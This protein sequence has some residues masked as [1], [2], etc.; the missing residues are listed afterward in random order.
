MHI[1]S[2]SEIHVKNNNY[3]VADLLTKKFQELND[4]ICEIDEANNIIRSSLDTWTYI[5]KCNVQSVNTDFSENKKKN[6]KY[7][8][9]ECIENEKLLESLTPQ[10]NNPLLFSGAKGVLINTWIIMIHTFLFFTNSFIVYPTN[11]LFIARLGYS[12]YITGIVLAM[13]PLSSFLILQLFIANISF[14][15]YKITI[16]LAVL[17]LLISNIL[18][19]YSYFFKSLSMMVLSRFLLGLGGIRILSN[20]YITEEIPSSNIL[21]YSKI[22]FLVVWLGYANGKLSY[23]YSYI[24]FNL[25]VLFLLGLLTQLE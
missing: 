24:V 3:N 4:K 25:K 5:V 13:T 16:I 19:V 9:I 21:Y 1:K 14:R 22:D 6:S 12:S 2:L 15:Y 7:N 23:I 17:V 11:Y 20:R 10:I 8:F 18:Y